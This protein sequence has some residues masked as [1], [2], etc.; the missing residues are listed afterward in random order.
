M[1]ILYN[2]DIVPVC[3]N[4]SLQFDAVYF[5]YTSMIAICCFRIC[6]FY[7]EA[8]DLLLEVFLILPVFNHLLVV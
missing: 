3:P 5:S 4:P 6:R 2:F 8:S 1:F 7:A